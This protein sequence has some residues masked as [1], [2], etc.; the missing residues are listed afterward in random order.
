MSATLIATV[1][2]PRSGKSTWARRQGL[3]IVCPDAIRLACHAR[4]YFAPFEPWTWALAY[5]MVEALFQAGHEQVI[6][7]ATN[8]TR[9]R[10]DDLRA[11]GSTFGEHPE[12]IGWNV[13][14]KVF[15][16]A[17]FIC[18][19]RAEQGNRPDLVK[20]IERMAAAYEPLGQ[21][22]HLYAAALEDE[23]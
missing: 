17:T 14:F 9:K 19:Q 7:D 5:T 4:P 11:Q 1:G 12:L 10:R 15:D 18:Q 13:C 20:V 6:F 3:P 22:E 23:P 21:D 16:T 2:L 8:T